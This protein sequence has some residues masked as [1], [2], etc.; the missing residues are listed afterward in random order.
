M[1]ISGGDWANLQRC[2]SLGPAEAGAA[3][4]ERRHVERLREDESQE[5]G[6]VPFLHGR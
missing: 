6:V 4:E 3:A 2:C 5:L 1:E